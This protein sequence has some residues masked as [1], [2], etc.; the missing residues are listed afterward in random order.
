MWLI[1]IMYGPHIRSGAAVHAYLAK[2][3]QLRKRCKVLQN[4]LSILRDWDYH[5]TN[6]VKFVYLS[7][8]FYSI[9]RVF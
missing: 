6:V 4:I 5:V 7:V 3:F 8:L 2:T 1:V 9:L